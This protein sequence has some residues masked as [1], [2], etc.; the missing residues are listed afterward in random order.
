MW[1]SI[2]T[3]VTTA[4]MK[5]D[6]SH[7]NTAL[8]PLSYLTLVISS[9]LLLILKLLKGQADCAGIQTLIYSQEATDFY[10]GLHVTASV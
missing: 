9:S 2:V 4:L 6:L 3:V 1:P 8:P 7:Y 10:G 5:K